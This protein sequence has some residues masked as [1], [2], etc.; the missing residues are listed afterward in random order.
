MDSMQNPVG[1]SAQTSVKFCTS[2]QQAQHNPSDGG[3]LAQA[4]S[5][6]MSATSSLYDNGRKGYLTAAE[7]HMRDMD[8]HGQGQL[9]NEQVAQIVEQTLALR[10]M[11][12][13]LRFWVFALFGA[14]TVLGLSNLGTAFAAAR[15]A[16]DTTVDSGTGVM[17]VKGSD[18]TRVSTMGTGHSVSAY[19]IKDEETNTTSLCIP[20]DQAAA[21]MNRT[22]H[23]TKTT[24]LVTTT[25]GEGG[26]GNVISVRTLGIAAT[27]TRYSST[28]NCFG[29]DDRTGEPICTDYT[30]FCGYSIDYGS[31]RRSLSSMGDLEENEEEDLFDLSSHPFTTPKH[32]ARHFASL[33]RGDIAVDDYYYDDDDDDE[34]RHLAEIYLR[35]NK[36]K[37]T[38]QQ[39]KAHSNYGR[40]PGWQWNIFI[41]C[42]WCCSGTPIDSNPNDRYT[43]S[44]GEDEEEWYYDEELPP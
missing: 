36:K 22:M 21:L 18:R 38:E 15:L 10:E 8:K 23:G 6:Q 43:F 41:G 35:Y 37:A 44:Q 14:V 1:E 2:S 25:D 17:I 42:T 34:G 19:L 4:M 16:K 11:N 39:C 5:K 31:R 26:S 40:T 12:Q 13:R 28:K 3:S 30:S 7:Q 33:V 29:R 9:S 24:L 27:G 20:R 32:H